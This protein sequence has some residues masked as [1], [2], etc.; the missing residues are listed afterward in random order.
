MF[1]KLKNK[2]MTNVLAEY[3][4]NKKNPIIMFV[5]GSQG[6]TSINNIM[7]SVLQNLKNKPY[8]VLY[9]TGNN[10]YDTFIEKCPK[11]DNIIVIPFVK[12]TEMLEHTSLI[13]TRGGATTATEICA[14]NVPSI[15]IPSPYV[16]NN[17]QE[18]NAQALVNRKAAYMIRESELSSERLIEQIDKIMEDTTL[19]N[20]MSQNTKALCYINAAEEMIVLI[21]KVV[22][23]IDLK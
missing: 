23:K 1:I 21:D 12:Q 16:P 14:F 3:G 6:S 22:N 10:H 20:L 11:A 4:L 5:M 7:L 2:K 18:I 9:V 8:Q 15:I 19:L 17:H 13:I